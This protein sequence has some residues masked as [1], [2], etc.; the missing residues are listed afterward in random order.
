[1]ADP[2]DTA[3]LRRR[4][5]TAWAE[6]LAKSPWTDLVPAVL[7]QVTPVIGPSKRVLLRDATGAALPVNGGSHDRLLAISG[8]HPLDIA[9]EWDGDLFRPLST[10]SDGRFVSLVGASHA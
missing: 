3:A 5:L 10:V 7:A 9:G 1:M 4:V 6:R 2:F 8:G